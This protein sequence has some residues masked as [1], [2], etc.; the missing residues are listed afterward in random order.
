MGGALKRK[1]K[2]KGNS[3]KYSKESMTL[4][5]DV[6]QAQTVFINVFLSSQPLYKAYI[7]VIVSLLQ[8]G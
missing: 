4:I 5:A 6:H 7:V 3:R 1:G 2:K 8:R